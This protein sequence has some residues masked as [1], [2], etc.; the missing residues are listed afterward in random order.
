[1]SACSRRVAALYENRNN[2]ALSGEQARLL[3][4]T[5]K[6]FLRSGAR[7]TGADRALFAEMAEQLANLEM[8]FAQ[9]VLAD[10]ENFVMEAGGKRSCRPYRY[11]ESVRSADRQGPQRFRPLR[12]DLVALQRRA[13]S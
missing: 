9:N 4:L 5:Y 12:L 10:E 1:M 13:L 2:L 7:L 6:S 8:K 11:G 3:E